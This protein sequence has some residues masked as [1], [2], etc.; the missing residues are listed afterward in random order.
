MIFAVFWFTVDKYILQMACTAPTTAI[1]TIWPPGH[2]FLLTMDA[3]PLWLCQS[4]T[5]TITT[6]TTIISLWNRNDN[7]WYNQVPQSANNKGDKNSDENY[8]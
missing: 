4:S 1:T 5:N 7:D 6:Q 3:Y 2:G 8:E